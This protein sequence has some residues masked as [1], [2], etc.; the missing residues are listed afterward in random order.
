[1]RNPHLGQDLGW[2]GAEAPE[3]IADRGLMVA[4]PVAMFTTMGKKL[5]TKAVM[6]AGS[7]QM[8]ILIIRIGTSATLGDGVEGDQQRIEHR[9]DERGRHRSPASINRPPAIANRKPITVVHSVS[10]Q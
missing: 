1:M 10:Q 9:A 7:E 5:M 8:L 4:S 3:H 6:T 2:G